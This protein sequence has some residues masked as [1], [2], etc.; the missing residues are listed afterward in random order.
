M[1][2]NKGTTPKSLTLIIYDNSNKPKRLTFH[3][4]NINKLNK[5]NTQLN[6]KY[7]DVSKINYHET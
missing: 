2:T 1:R 7:E 6:K 5:N 4:G 3:W